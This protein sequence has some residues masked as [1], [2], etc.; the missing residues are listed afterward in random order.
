MRLTEHFDAGSAAA[1]LLLFNGDVLSV[2][3]IVQTVARVPRKGMTDPLLS[4]KLPFLAS[5]MSV[6]NLC[7]ASQYIDDRIGVDPKI[8]VLSSLGYSLTGLLVGFGASLCNGC[9]LG[10]GICGLG[11]MSRRSF[12]AVITFVITASLTATFTT[13]AFQFYRYTA[14][15]RGDDAPMRIEP[16]GTMVTLMVAIAAVVPRTILRSYLVLSHDATAQTNDAKIPLTNISGCLFAFGLAL[17]GMVLPSKVY[18][19]LNLSGIADGS[20]DLTL[21]SATFGGVLISWLSYQLVQG[22]SCI[23]TLAVFKEPL[24]VADFSLPTNTKIDPSLIVGATMFGIGWGLGGICPGTALF[25]AAVGTDVVIA[26]WWPAFFA[27][28]YAAD[29]LSA[30]ARNGEREQLERVVDID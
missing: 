30:P 19:F 24:S 28:C 20:Y 15:L 21:A 16:I 25:Q 5:F 9:T 3:S 2:V 10:H 26:Y 8:P 1:G 22:Q 6:S 27:G 18:G 11:R 14:I 4:W 17:S 23:S 12:V 13:P 29:K 7:F